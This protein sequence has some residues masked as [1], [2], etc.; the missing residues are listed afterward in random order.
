MALWHP[1]PLNCRM[2]LLVR[3]N[4]PNYDPFAWNNEQGWCQICEFSLCL[5]E[6]R[7]V[8]LLIVP[9]VGSSNLVFLLIVPLVGWSNLVFLLI[10]P[11]VAALFLV[12]KHPPTHP[13][14]KPIALGC[15]WSPLSC[16]KNTRQHTPTQKP[17][18]LGCFWSPIVFEVVHSGSWLPSHHHQSL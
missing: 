8:F 13:N 7:M 6:L 5:V 16:E 10:V 9:L 11:L 3:I 4:A 15:Y 2:S 12:K 17:I 1:L 18:A 14:T